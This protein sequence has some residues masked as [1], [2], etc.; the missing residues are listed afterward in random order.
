[1]RVHVTPMSRNVKTGPIMTTMSVSETCPDACPF[2]SSG[3]YAESGPVNIHWRKLD[4][5]KTG[6]PW[7]AFLDIVERLLP[8]QLWRHN[9]SGLPGIGDSL[10]V[11]ALIQLVYANAKAKARG[12][13]YTHK[14]MKTEWERGAVYSAN[15]NG[16]TINLSGNNPA[17]ADELADMGIGPVVTVLPADQLENTTTPKGRRVVVCPAVTRDNVSCA[18]C[19]LC[20]NA[21]RDCIVGFPAHG[22][23][24]RKASAIASNP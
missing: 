19:G 12:F 10:D 13:T 9:V 24:K 6:M 3:C 18:S 20:A 14:P 21:K 8:T 4:S 15:L 5:G 2:K 22:V 1:M 16:F 17:H 11:P 23:Q 7:D